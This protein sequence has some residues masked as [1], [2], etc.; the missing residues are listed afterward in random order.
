M[1]TKFGDKSQPYEI[2]QGDVAHPCLYEECSGIAD[3]VVRGPK[4]SELPIC[5]QHWEY[6]NRRTRGGL[7]EIVRTLD[8]PA[9]FRPDCHDEA[10]A[11]MEGPEGPARPVCQQHLDDLSWIDVPEAALVRR[12]SWLA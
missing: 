5:Q 10:I 2:G 8:R 11:V 4:R 1:F 3:I 6:L 7:I 12:P 9:C